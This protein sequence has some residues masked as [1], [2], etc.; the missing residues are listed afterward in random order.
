[1][2]RPIQH[3]ERKRYCHSVIELKGAPALMKFSR[4]LPFHRTLLNLSCQ[5]VGSQSSAFWLAEVQGYSWLWT[6]AWFGGRPQTCVGRGRWWGVSLASCVGQLAGEPRSGNRRLS[7]STS[8]VEQTLIAL[9]GSRV[10]ERSI[11][12]LSRF[13]GF[14]PPHVA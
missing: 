3:S 4:P 8:L 10:L 13:P 14:T 12:P 11:L 9:L 2:S 6:S 5:P 1:M 7:I